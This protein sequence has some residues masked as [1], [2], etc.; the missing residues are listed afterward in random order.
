MVC[1][2]CA[3]SF[4]F[5]RKQWVLVVHSINV[6]LKTISIITNKQD[7]NKTIS[8]KIIRLSIEIEHD[9]DQIQIK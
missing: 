7:T 1:I 8:G 9:I 5:N 2:H 3:Y 6:I 4:K